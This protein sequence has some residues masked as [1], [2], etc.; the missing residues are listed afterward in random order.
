MARLHGARCFTLRHDF[1]DRF[2]SGIEPGTIVTTR[3][4]LSI[5]LGLISVKILQPTT[6]PQRYAAMR[7]T[8][9]L[10]IVKP[11][12]MFETKGL[13]V[14]MVLLGVSSDYDGITISRRIRLWS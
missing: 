6:H 3:R 4:Q 8:N 9:G 1:I 10:S 11:T 12:A 2:G 5:A 14:S 13:W 7:Q